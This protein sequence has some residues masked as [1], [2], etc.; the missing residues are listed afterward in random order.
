MSL[1]VAL[2]TGLSGLRGAQA[3]MATT[4]N[5]IAN[6]NTDGYSRKTVALTSVTTGGMSTGVDI[7]AVRR[8]IDETL[9]RDVLDA[10]S[11]LE[12]R[13]AM[14]DLLAGIEQ[15]FG[16]AGEAQSLGS[17]ISN[18]RDAIQALAEQPENT[19]LQSTVLNAGRQVTAMFNDVAR[20][21]QSQRLNAERGIDASVK[22]INNQIANIVDLNAQIQYGLA[23]GKD[24][25]SLEDNRDKAVAKIAEQIDVR[26]YVRSDGQMVV[27]MENGR[28][29]V[30]SNIQHPI[31][32]TPVALTT[33]TTTFDSIALDGYDITSEIRSGKLAALIQ[34]RDQVLPAVYGELNQLAGSMRTSV[35]ST[36]LATTNTV[37]DPGTDTNLF[38]N[39]TSATDFLG[40]IQVHPDLQANAA[41]LA[42]T[43]TINLQIARDLA[44]AMTS[45]TYNFTAVA[46][47]LPAMTKGF[48]DYA[49]SVLDDVAGRVADS[50]AKVDYQQTFVETLKAKAGSVSDVNID[51]ELSQLIIYQKAYAA[52]GKVIQ[53]TS[54][55]MDTLINLVR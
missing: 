16:T 40:T 45:T 36:G 26:T 25:T 8:E 46:N 9:T 4:A 29:L 14:E 35:T 52:S 23:T 43:P 19:G 50:K 20:S 41:L 21:I 30:D 37:A 39:A 31:D 49:N 17:V 22:E 42:G 34:V 2:F 1:S 5:N 13:K 32:F 28:V 7:S 53:T 18:F 10:T 12:Q 11:D 47:G 38:F 6:A 15:L 48:S 51:E 54:E 3:A 33:P 27:S 24:T 55:L 44:T